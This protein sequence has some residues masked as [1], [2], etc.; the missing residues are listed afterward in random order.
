MQ[1]PIRIGRIIGLILLIQATT[2]GVIY[3]KLLPPV[4]S[5]TFLTTA[6]PHAASI[7]TALL[8]SLAVSSMTFVV[9]LVALPIF[10]AG[11]E[12]LA[13]AYVAL[14]VFGMA[15][16]AA[17][18]L[19]FRNLLALSLEYAK[20]TAPHELLQSIGIAA[21]ST[22]LLTHFTNLISG[23]ALMLAL[24][25]TLFRLSLVPRLLSIAGMIASVI[26]IIDVVQPLVGARFSFLY[27]Y[28]AGVCLL[29]LVL[30][31]LVKGFNERRP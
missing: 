4:T 3:S 7:R 11:G 13:I 25:L 12:R 2:T 8:L 17:E 26:G 14:S 20:P 16:T 30:W 31:L 19:G 21:H 15:T 18:T 6:A 5:S 27:V 22:A 10:R 24:Y 23:H 29:A 1:S 9:A 28:P